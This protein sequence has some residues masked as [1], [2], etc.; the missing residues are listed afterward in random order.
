MMTTVAFV[1]L[2]ACANVAGLLLTRAAGRQKELAIRF[3]L[4]ASR[5]RV[6][7]QLV[8]EGLV[9]SLLGGGAG[10]LLTYVGIS[11][12][13]AGLTFNEAISAVP[14]SLD[15]HVLVFAVVVSLLSAMLS[16]L[17]PALRASRAD[18]NTGLKSEGRTA[19]AGRS[20]SRLRALLVTCEI[21]LA[22]FLLIGTSLL[23]RGVF[24]LDH[25][26]LGFRTDHILTAS[27]ALDHTRYKDGS[28]QLLFVRR[29]MNSLQ[30]IPGVDSAAVVSDLPAT[31]P[32]TV[33]IHIE[34]ERKLRDGE[35]R[36]TLDAVVT[37][38]YFT[39]VGI[40]L[41]R[42]R[43][44][45]E[46]DDAHAPRVVLVNEEFVRRY[47]EHQN[48]LG[49]RI[50]PDRE[51]AAPGWSE[52]VGVVSNVKSYSEET[53]FDPEIYES[54]LQRPVSSFSVLLRSRVDPENL[55]SYLRQAVA[56]L[57]AELPPG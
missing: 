30:Q 38:D 6:V 4:G 21:G 35:Q 43:A 34:G 29:L 20:Q 14:I 32:D 19:S 13:R 23:I 11:I 48:P 26:Q 15:R 36:N 46:T 25:Q 3:S 33:P 8:T 12:L 41:Q 7:R 52:I 44:F 56:H 22:L 53:R 17:A 37:A 51:G 16:S 55:A 40:P 57:D 5:M 45:T 1:L 50:Q 49:R 54:I 31:N 24:L 27:V 42:G 2:I 10:L 18:T 9:I 39:A 47:F 28:D